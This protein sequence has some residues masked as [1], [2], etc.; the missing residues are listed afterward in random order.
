MLWLL[1]RHKILHT[2]QQTMLASHPRI[3]SLFFAAFRSEWK[4]YRITSAHHVTYHTFLSIV[5]TNVALFCRTA[6][7]RNRSRMAFSLCV[8]SSACSVTRSQLSQPF[9][10]LA[11]DGKRLRAHLFSYFVWSQFPVSSKSA[12]NFP[13]TRVDFIIPL[14]IYMHMWQQPADCQTPSASASLGK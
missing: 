3:L 7:S 2:Q 11:I 4:T 9:T 14:G 6:H 13:H 8:C 5:S 12:I 1:C 10:C